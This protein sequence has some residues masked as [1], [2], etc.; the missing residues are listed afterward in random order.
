MAHG[1]YY[2]D[3]I[4]EASLSKHDIGTVLRKNGIKSKSQVFAL[5]M[6]T[7]GDMSVSKQDDTI[8]DIDLFEDIRE[9]EHLIN[10]AKLK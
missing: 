4:A 9:C 6:E 8:P 2:R 3:N 10:N 5:V 1:E 7:T